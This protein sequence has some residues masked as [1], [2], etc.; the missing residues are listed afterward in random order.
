MLY[1]VYALHQH[2]TRVRFMHVRLRAYWYVGVVDRHAYGCQ[3]KTKNFNPL[4]SS[5][6][7]KKHR[8]VNF[9]QFEG[10]WN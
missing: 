6:G 5:Y 10:I 8:Q 3:L 1:I 4:W 2:V 7:K 9:A